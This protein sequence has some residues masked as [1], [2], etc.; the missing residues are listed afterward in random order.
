MVMEQTTAEE[1]S[2]SHNT[3]KAETVEAGAEDVRQ[4]D[5]F[6]CVPLDA[7]TWKISLREFARQEII[8]MAASLRIHSLIEPIVCHMYEEGL[9]WGVCGKLRFEGAKHAKLRDIL[10]RVHRFSS[11]DEMIEWAIAENLHRRDLTALE[12]AESYG[13]L[14]GLRKKQFPEESVVQG[15]AMS[16]EEWSGA[17]PAERTVRKYLEIDARIG[18]HARTVGLVR[19]GETASF[20]KLNHLLEVSRLENDD[21]QA[22]LLSKTIYEGWTTQK[23]KHE[24]D[25]ALGIVKPS[26]DKVLHCNVCDSPTEE[27]ETFKACGMCSA[28]F[29][30]W[31][32]ERREKSEQPQEPQPVSKPEA[33]Q[34]ATC[35][36]CRVSLLLIHNDDGS[37]KLLVKQRKT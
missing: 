37:H 32:Q 4:I 11:E 12:R 8:N 7:I 23:L 1:S 33:S 26:A 15:I 18:K 24:V 19:Q 3:F 29:Q 17:K 35:Q 25:V 13:Q 28:E 9:Y 31:L 14:A 10:T 2:V 20:L 27:F 16:V 22:E 34:V 21:K 5:E 6:K 30:I 36:Q